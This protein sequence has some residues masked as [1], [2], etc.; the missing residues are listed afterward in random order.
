MKN[1]KIRKMK[2]SRGADLAWFAQKG[3]GNIEEL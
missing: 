2:I 3:P 1:T